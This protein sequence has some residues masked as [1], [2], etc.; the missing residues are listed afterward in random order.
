MSSLI[1]E[2]CGPFEGAVLPETNG[3]YRTIQQFFQD[4][5][6]QNGDPQYQRRLTGVTLIRNWNLI[7]EFEGC[8][9][10]WGQQRDESPE[11]FCVPRA[12]TMAGDPQK[13]EI[14]E[15]FEAMEQRSLSFFREEP[16]GE[17]LA[18]LVTFR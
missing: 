15:R 18:L 3:L 8:L 16:E 11:T 17:D 4:Y 5:G 10:G 1:W 6:G 13:E 12:K 7:G 2:D 9:S 14:L